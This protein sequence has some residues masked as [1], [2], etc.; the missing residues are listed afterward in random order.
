MM[1]APIDAALETSPLF[2]KPTS[3]NRATGRF[4]EA[5]TWRAFGYNLIMLFLGI[6]AFT[7]AVTAFSLGITVAILIVGLPLAAGLLL[8]ARWFGE[9]IRTTTNF[10]LGTSIQ[11]PLPTMRQKGFWGFVTS[12]FNDTQ[13]WRALAHHSICL[14]TSLI[15]FSFSITFLAAGLATVTYGAWYRYAPAQQA[16]DGTWHQGTQL[17]TDYFVDTPTEIAFFGLVG[18]A[19]TLYVWPA[20]NN[21]LAKMQAILAAALL[22]PTD[23]SMRKYQLEMEKIQAAERT[24]QRM[25]GIERD[26]HDITQAQL[27]AIAMKVGDAKDRLET[28]E[29]ADTVLPTLESAHITAKTALTDLRGLIQGIHPAALNDG[30]AIALET[31]VANS[32]IAVDGGSDI[33]GTLSK[34]VEVAAYYSIAELLTNAAKHSGTQRVLL[35]VRTINGTLDIVVQDQGCGGAEFRHAGGNPGIRNAGQSGTGLRGIAERVN[36]VNGTFTLESPHG[37]PTTAHITLPQIPKAG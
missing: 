19:I 3:A 20:I 35:N 17:W 11:P 27:V 23:G 33:H 21:G 14:V 12:A 26:L 8:G 10:N 37:G 16:T 22:G 6:L 29:P 28:R 31:L 13:S 5:A 9:A 18:L 36:S 4:F 1:S 2:T 7:Y 30:L 34:S 25:S 24:A 32:A 15:A